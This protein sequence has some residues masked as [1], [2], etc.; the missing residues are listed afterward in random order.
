M[1]EA[2]TPTSK[3][4]KVAIKR[5]NAGRTLK[6]EWLLT[7]DAFK[8]WKV[9]TSLDFYGDLVKLNADLAPVF[10]KLAN[11]VTLSKSERA[12]L[13]GAIGNVQSALRKL[14]KNEKAS[15]IADTDNGPILLDEID[16]K[17]V[18]RYIIRRAA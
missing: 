12:M 11:E 17:P 5:A 18:T 7:N 3:A 13:R 1:P 16:G 2:F 10:T 8:G 4:R 9:G 14:T 15:L 6:A